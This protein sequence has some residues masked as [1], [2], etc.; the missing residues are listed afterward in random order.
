MLTRP[1]LEYLLGLVCEF[2]R[3]NVGKTLKKKGGKGWGKGPQT[4]SYSSFL[5]VP[6][7]RGLWRILIFLFKNK[8]HTRWG[9][10]SL[11]PSL[12]SFF[13]PKSSPLFFSKT[14]KQALKDSHVNN[15]HIIE[16]EY[17]R[18]KELSKSLREIESN[19]TTCFLRI[20]GTGGI[21]KT[22][23]N[24]DLIMIQGEKRFPSSFRWFY[25]CGS[26]SERSNAS[27]NGLSLF[28]YSF[29]PNCNVFLNSLVIN[30]IMYGNLKFLIV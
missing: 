8:P 15:R 9:Y 16:Q 19:N 2:G 10:L 27:L 6:Q 4:S 3:E 22:T 24:Y 12:S 1:P 30:V 28:S 26:K 21:G 17:R 18:V 7:I 14:H 20:H 29:S 25:L 13:L 11:P 5:L 23:L